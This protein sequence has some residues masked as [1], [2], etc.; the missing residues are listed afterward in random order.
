MMAT[1]NAV[2]IDNQDEGIFLEVVFNLLVFILPALPKPLL[3]EIITK[4]DFVSCAGDV[5]FRPQSNSRSTMEAPT[6][7]LV[8]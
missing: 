7:F 8:I 3:V 1:L 4:A 2:T 6:G 5:V